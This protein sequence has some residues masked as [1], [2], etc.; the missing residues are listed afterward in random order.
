LVKQWTLGRSKKVHLPDNQHD[1][2]LCS[3][4]GAQ[5]ELLFSPSQHEMK[6]TLDEKLSGKIKWHNCYI[7][8]C[9][10]NNLLQT[11]QTHWQHRPKISGTDWP[12]LQFQILVKK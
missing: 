10:R 8:H 6:K 12:R 3:S 1:T 4:S 9:D 2:R 7:L 11:F 5:K